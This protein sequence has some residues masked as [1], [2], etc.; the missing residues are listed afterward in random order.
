[1]NPDGRC[2]ILSGGGLIINTA[3]HTNILT[4]I[5]QSVRADAAKGCADVKERQ[6]RLLPGEKPILNHMHFC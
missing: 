6:K 1:M 5:A 4:D 2:G 3:S